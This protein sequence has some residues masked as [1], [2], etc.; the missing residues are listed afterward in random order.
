MDVL[1]EAKPME[2]LWGLVET[3]EELSFLSYL[4][5]YSRLVKGRE[6]EV[7][8]ALACRY[9]DH[10]VP[11]SHSRMAERR[12]RAIQMLGDLGLPQFSSPVIAALD[13]PSHLVAMIA[14]STLMARP[15]GEFGKAVL[16]KLDR[17][18]LW[19]PTYLAALMAAPGHTAG[20]HLRETLTDRNRSP[21]VRSVAAIALTYLNDHLAAAPAYAV[22]TEETDRDLVATS[23][24]LLAQVGHAE[25]LP[26]VRAL[27]DSPDEVLR[28]AAAKALGSL[29]TEEDCQRLHR[30]ALSDPSN[31]VALNAARALLAARGRRLLEA[32][33]ASDHRRS[34][35][36]VQVLTES[37][38]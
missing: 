11:S 29:G 18:T 2:A 23:L 15:S 14:A 35:L 37:G 13:D 25:H 7:V 38:A 27:L 31:W 28:G 26:R 36:A 20:P 19:R 1:V 30:A 32:L 24:R 16:A 12:A 5:R 3:G 22:A 8:D 17:F 6:R 4:L 21:A 10:V 34:P 9:L 33:A